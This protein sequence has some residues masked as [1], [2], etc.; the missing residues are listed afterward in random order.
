VASALATVEPGQ[1]ARLERRGVES[2]ITCGDLPPKGQGM[3]APC[4]VTRRGRTKLTPRSERF[5]SV[6]PLPDGS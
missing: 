5:C 3:P 4:T 2:N 6:S 1:A